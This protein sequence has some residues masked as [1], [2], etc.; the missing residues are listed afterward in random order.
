MARVNFIFYSFAYK[1]T[2]K[3]QN[4]IKENPARDILPHTKQHR[5]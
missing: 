2:D 4:N 3:E 5:G 1:M